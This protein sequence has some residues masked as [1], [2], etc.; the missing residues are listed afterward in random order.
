MIT[1]L[2]AEF[3][4]ISWDIIDFVLHC[5]C[6]SVGECGCM[7]VQLCVCVRERKEE[8]EKKE[9][10]NLQATGMANLERRSL[11]QMALTGSC[12]I[13]AR[14][15]EESLQLRPVH[16]YSC[17]GLGVKRRSKVPHIPESYISSIC[18]FMLPM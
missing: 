5:V 8:E 18:P 6:V 7:G 17:P 12:L 13:W 4:F 1:L 10:G 3:V 11:N 14:G 9:M 16:L 2:K 15:T